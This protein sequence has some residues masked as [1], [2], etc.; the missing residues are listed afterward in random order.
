MIKTSCVKRIEGD[1]FIVVRSSYMTICKGNAT[2]A[3]LIHYF[4]S[5]HNIKVGARANFVNESTEKGPKQPPTL[6][7]WHTNV[8]LEDALMGIGK[9]HSIQKAREMLLDLGVITIHRNPNPNYLFDNT[10]HYLFHPE[11]VNILLDRLPVNSAPD[12]IIQHEPKPSTPSAEII[13][14]IPN[15]TIQRSIQEEVPGPTPGAQK[16]VV[17]KKTQA[18][19][20]PPREFWQPFVDTWHDFHVENC[21][22]EAPSI[23][24]KPL[25]DLGK[26][27][28]LLLLRAR[29]KKA[30]WSEKYM[31][32]ALKFFLAESIKEEWLKKHLTVANLVEQFDPIFVRAASKN[33]GKPPAKPFAE[34]IQYII[35]RWNE[36]DMDARLI[37]PELYKKLEEKQI[38]PMGYR[39][40]FTGKDPDEQKCNAVK[41]WLDHISKKTATA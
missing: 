15:D 31:V 32:D 1:T 41:A 9:K 40:Q 11:A 34:E 16:K 23:V 7:Q 35:E 36:G 6:L 39:E 19:K 3:A 22:G 10:L 26:L 12:E 21:N 28:D 33:G 5:W 17:K 29:R 25:T 38:V 4:E 18:E 24:G 8:M 2:A 20:R 13:R 14:T 37:T 30:T 27:Y